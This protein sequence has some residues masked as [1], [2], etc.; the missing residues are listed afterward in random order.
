MPGPTARD[1]GLFGVTAVMESDKFDRAREAM[2]AEI[3]KLQAH[4]P[5]TSELRKGIKQFVSAM[6]ASRKTM[7]GQAQDLGANWLAANDLNFS[8]RYLAAVKAATPV[9]LQRVAKRYL[10]PEN[11]TLYALLPTGTIPKTVATTVNS[12]SASIKKFQLANGLRL[13][14]KEDNRLPF[15][16]FRTVFK[17]GLLVESLQDEGITQ[18]PAGCFSK[19]PRPVRQR[20]S[21]WRSSRLAAISIPTR[22]TTVSACMRRC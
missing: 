8:E 12:R 18:L 10:A 7:Q 16:E 4:P 20:R 9:E 22:E 17:G 19:E 14:V 13:L 21:P 15:V 5:T 6:L 11:R 3:E 2:L 1:P